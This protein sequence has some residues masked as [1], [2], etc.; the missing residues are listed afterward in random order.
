M[1]IFL[2]ND[3]QWALCWFSFEVL[4]ISYP[5]LKRSKKT[6]FRFQEEEK[7][8]N[9]YRKIGFP[10]MFV[11][12]WFFIQTKPNVFMKCL[13]F[14]I[15]AWAVGDTP[16]PVYNLPCITQFI[17]Y[18]ILASGYG[19]RNLYKNLLF[20]RNIQYSKTLQL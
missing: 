20:I 8:K 10:K 18:Q 17:N 12:G 16:I 5:D 4:I 9:S 19:V 15:V 7:L 14:V 6:I 3:F 1:M 13:R 11:L 2:R